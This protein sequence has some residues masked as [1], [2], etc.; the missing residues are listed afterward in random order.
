LLIRIEVAV[1]GRSQ[2]TPG[3]HSHNCRGTLDSC[4]TAGKDMIA[5]LFDELEV[6]LGYQEVSYTILTNYPL[7]RPYCNNPSQSQLHRLSATVHEAAESTCQCELDGLPTQWN[8]DRLARVA[9]I[10]AT[11]VKVRTASLH[12]YSQDT[13][14]EQWTHLSAVSA[15]RVLR[16]LMVLLVQARVVWPSA[17]FPP[18]LWS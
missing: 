12:K 16:A 13:L 6:R 4:V 17:A 3:I 11:F 2:G 10:L 1:R 7:W 15:I 14:F 9:T 5:A 8:G 18:W